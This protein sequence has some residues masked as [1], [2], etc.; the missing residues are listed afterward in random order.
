[1]ED[2]VSIKN[3]RAKNPK[4]GTRKIAELLGVSRNTVKKA[5]AS[6]EAPKYKSRTTAINKHVLPFEAFIKESFLKKKLKASRILK[7]IISKGYKGSQ[8]ALYAYIRN[9]LKPLQDEVSRNNPNAYKSYETAP[10]EQMQFD[11][12]HYTVSIGGELIKIYVH[13]TIL[14]FS[15]YKFYS[16]TLSMTQSDVLNAL[17]ESFIFFGGVCERIQVD[18]AKVFVDNASRDNFVWNKRFLHFC[19]FYGI[20]PTRSI[21]GHPWSKGKVEKPFDYLENHFIMGNEF[22]DFNELQQRLKLF[23]EETNSLV[24]AATKERTKQRFETKEQ[25]Y[26]NPL[27]IDQKTGEIR[28]YVGFKEEFRKV[29]KDALISYKGNKYSV[30]HYFASKEVWLK[31][32]YGTTLQ[33]FSTKNRLIASHTISLSKA[34]VFINEEHYKGY[35]ADGFDTL[36]KSTSRLQT[37]FANYARITQFIENVKVQKRINIADHLHK[38]ANLFEYYNDTD[39]IIAMEECF[40]LNMFNATIIKGFITQHAKVKEEDINLLNIDLPK[41]DVKRDLKDYKL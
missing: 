2:W 10:G 13:Q 12:A 11:W 19:G 30:P 23:Q 24:H 27:P 41:G 35:R 21:P 38:I 25:L 9:E 40:T 1:M 31:V 28:R 5:L 36:A 6:E 3:L 15:R 20:K 39:C 22:R 8:Y 33:I 17:E 32:L 18:N 34:E 16:V 14:G 37:R 26:L 4:L 29:T 7:D